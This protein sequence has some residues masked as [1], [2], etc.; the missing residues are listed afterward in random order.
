MDSICHTLISVV[1]LYRQRDRRLYEPP[2]ERSLGS[3]ERRWLADSREVNPSQAP[4]LVLVD[5]HQCSAQLHVDGVA[6]VDRFLSETANHDG[7]LVIHT[8]L[9]LVQSM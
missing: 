2:T 8:R 6:T 5:K 3:R 4:L 7:C 1:S 9:D